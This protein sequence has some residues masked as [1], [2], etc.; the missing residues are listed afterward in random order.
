MATIRRLP[1]FSLV[2]Q[3]DKVERAVMEDVRKGVLASMAIVASRAKRSM[4]QTVRQ[5]VGRKRRGK[6]HYPSA[7]GHPPAPDTGQLM[8]S[9]G[10]SAVLDKLTGLVT[11]AVG[12]RAGGGSTERGFTLAD[13]ASVLEDPAR[14]NRPF[15]MPQWRAERPNLIERIRAINRNRRGVTP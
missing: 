10:F 3:A 7:P 2:M 11:G 4:A 5:S 6:V 1:G 12:V 9:L 13:R 8:Q 14:L 15:V